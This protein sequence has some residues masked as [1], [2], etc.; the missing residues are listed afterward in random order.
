MDQLAEYRARQQQRWCE[1]EQLLQTQ[2]QGSVGEKDGTCMPKARPQPLADLKLLEESSV[3]PCGSCPGTPRE[4]V[5]RQRRRFASER[6]AST[7]E[8]DSM[9][10]SIARDASVGHTLGEAE[11]QAESSFCNSCPGTPRDYRSRQQQRFEAELLRRQQVQ[12][13]EQEPPSKPTES[14]GTQATSELAQPSAEISSSPPTPRRMRGSASL[15]AIS[16]A[17]ALHASDA[18]PLPG[19]AWPGHQ[20]SHDRP[21]SASRNSSLPPR[22]PTPSRTNAGPGRSLNSSLK[23][24][25]GKSSF[26]LPPRPPSPSCSRRPPSP[27]CSRH[28]KVERTMGTC[29]Q[30]L[31]CTNEGPLGLGIFCH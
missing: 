24:S 30:A 29:S 5:E 26:A 23:Q 25:T 6:Q 22:P 8:A 13:P 2:E 17:R 31:G 1:A 27:S 28:Q 15:R 21:Q 7:A 16:A 18:E 12:E 20:H 9:Q 3:E 11:L 10:P 14:V 4:Y 19:A